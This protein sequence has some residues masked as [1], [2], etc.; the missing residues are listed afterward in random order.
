MKPS[1]T[2]TVPA[3]LTPGEAVLNREAAELLGRGTIK[4]L[5]HAGV[6]MR[7]VPGYADGITTVPVTQLAQANQQNIASARVEWQKTIDA[8]RARDAAGA[9]TM[10][11][12]TSPQ[13]TAASR[14]GGMKGYSASGP[15]T[16]GGIYGDSTIGTP[17]AS[18]SY[19]QQRG[20]VADTTPA[21]EPV[22]NKPMSAPL[23]MSRRPAQQVDLMDQFKDG[24]G[25][26][27]IQGFAYGTADVQPKFG[28][29][30]G[31]RE[32]AQRFKYPEAYSPGRPNITHGFDPAIN[33]GSRGP[34]PYQYNLTE[35]TG[36]FSK[37]PPRGTIGAGKNLIP[38][39]GMGMTPISDVTMNSGRFD[40]VGSRP[41]IQPEPAAVPPPAA[42][43]VPA[44]PLNSGSKVNWVPGSGVVEDLWSGRPLTDGGS[45]GSRVAAGIRGV[46][47]PAIQAVSDFAP[48]LNVMG[49]MGYND[50][51]MERNVP[52]LADQQNPTTGAL[53]QETALQFMRS[54]AMGM[55][56]LQI[57]TGAGD[58][59]AAAPQQPAPNV[60]LPAGAESTVRSPLAAPTPSYVQ[61]DQPRESIPQPVAA[62]PAWG[63][64]VDINDVQSGEGV[65]RN[66]TGTYGYRQMP[67]GDLMKFD[68]QGNQV[69]KLGNVGSRQQAGGMRLTS[70][71]AMTPV[72]NPLA[73]ETERRMAE[74]TAAA[75]EAKL[76]RLEELAM[77]GGG[78]DGT[79]EGMG[80]Q[81]RIRRGAQAA[82]SERTGM[83]RAQIADASQRATQQMQNE[84]T[85]RG[86]NTQRDIAA[87]TNRVAND[88]LQQDAQIEASKLG[89]T[90]NYQT[91]ELG[92]KDRATKVLED[93]QNTLNAALAAE[94]NR[95]R[96]ELSGGWFGG[97][98]SEDEVRAK[99]Y[100]NLFRTSG[101]TDG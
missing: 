78:G 21:L 61:L 69:G 70:Y 84:I 74:R 71:G 26:E 75:E 47:R 48:A 6:Q 39:P 73:Y 33:P 97:V 20:L 68:A 40:R 72:D 4:K 67:N 64:Q 18:G 3:M 1:P 9:T 93:K 13:S 7:Q 60:T 28:D 29:L 38:A 57:A 17:A 95:I 80:D 83:R 79:F 27:E 59:E 52:R 25:D 42:N 100:Y 94:M 82:L 15:A 11:P 50:A 23:G 37:V 101:R 34:A 14:L 81:K 88:R 63:R 41:S 46:A 32:V 77:T 35:V 43:L 2:D 85:M 44:G 62:Q 53:A 65:M 76:A 96:E 12:V 36:P 90:M 86:Q 99:A 98:P 16:S 58:Q 10:T 51:A 31:A 66:A 55:R 54:P 22:M 56:A 45:V 89:N 5:N 30:P 24:L 87:A 8:K 92:I 91:S 49:A 19:L